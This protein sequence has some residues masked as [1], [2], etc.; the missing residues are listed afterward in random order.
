MD[1]DLVGTILSVGVEGHDASEWE[2]FLGRF[3][4]SKDVVE[5]ERLLPY[6]TSTE[7]SKNLLR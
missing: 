7:R 1:E 2:K 5:K 6:L 4:S 3:Q